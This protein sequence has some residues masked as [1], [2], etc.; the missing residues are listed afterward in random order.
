MTVGLDP[1]LVGLYKWFQAFLTALHQD[2]Y[3]SVLL[4]III[5]FCLIGSDYYR[6]WEFYLCWLLIT[7][8]VGV[9]L[10]AQR[11]VKRE[12][13]PSLIV[14]AIASCGPALYLIARGLSIA[15]MHPPKLHPIL[16]DNMFILAFIV[17]IFA[18]VNRG[19]LIFTTYRCYM[20][21][22]QGLRD[23]G[24]T[25]VSIEDPQDLADSQKFKCKSKS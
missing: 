12:S 22:G 16:E 23:R 5:A 20:N 19:L 17:G 18:L 25:Y 10:W 13:T 7:W 8:V 6:N 2:L 11:S 3:F 21:F 24:T 1:K 4:L 15:I 9:D 14:T